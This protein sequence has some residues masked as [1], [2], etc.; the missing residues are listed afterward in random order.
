MTQEVW[1]I[2][3]NVTRMNLEIAAS[4]RFM[5]NPPKVLRIIDAPMSC[6]VAIIVKKKKDPIAKTNP[7]FMELSAGAAAIR[8]GNMS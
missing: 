7:S 4:M 3:N 6:N 5:T 1:V 2:P 8:N